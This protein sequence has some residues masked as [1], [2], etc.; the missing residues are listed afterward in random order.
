[1]LNKEMDDFE[2]LRQLKARY[3]R[4]GDLKLWDLHADCL[5]EDYVGVF[6]G[7]PR[8][9][10]DLPTTGRFEGRDSLISA[11]R[12]FL[13]QD[14]VTVHQIFAPEITITSATTAKG[15]WGLADHIRMPTCIFRGWGH[16]NEDYIKQ[17]GI[18]RIK[19]VTVTRLHVE[20]TWL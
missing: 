17:N 16:Y 14:T 12:Q 3:I 13:K 19:N 15:I 8:P 1:V 9:S 10:R 7:M 4:S 11:M 2:A 5:T 18:W 6:D 20:E